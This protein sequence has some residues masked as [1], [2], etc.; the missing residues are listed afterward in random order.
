MTPI[1]G[2]RRVLL[3]LALAVVLTTACVREKRQSYVFEH[4]FNVSDPSF[5][6]SLDSLGNTMVPGN[7]A[8]ILQNGDEIF[9]AMTGA[10][11]AAKKSVCLESFIFMDDEAGRQVADALIDAA[12]EGVEVRVLVDWLRS[13]MGGPTD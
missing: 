4:Q 11:R 13:K 1:A 8:V 5:R 9:P 7:A 2:D 12:R 3:A 10:I 6:R